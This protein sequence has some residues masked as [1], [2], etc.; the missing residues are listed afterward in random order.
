MGR[1]G[2]IGSSGSRDYEFANVPV[3]TGSLL[4]HGYL[5]KRPCVD[6][7]AQE[8][9]PCVSK[10]GKELGQVHISR[11]RLAIRAYREEQGDD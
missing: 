6:C 1:K 7:P 4:P 10:T 9:E 5:R 3:R 8:G 11:R 2:L